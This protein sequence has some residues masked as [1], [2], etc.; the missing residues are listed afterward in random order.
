MP[1]GPTRQQSH[2][3]D[4]VQDFAVGLEFSQ[5]NIAIL[6]QNTVPHGIDNGL[7]LFVDFFEQEVFITFFLGSNRVPRDLARYVLYRLA[8]KVAEAHALASDFGHFSIVKEDH[9]TRVVEECGNIGSDEVFIL[10]ETNNDRRGAFCSQNGIG[11]TLRQRNNGKRA[12]QSL[13]CCASGFSKRKSILNILVNQ[14][15]N[16]L[17][18]SF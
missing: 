17:S 15:R 6:D 18:I 2:P 5:G 3:F 14:M 10:S 13:E 4:C 12:C 7:R 1:R 16:N 8:V 11:L 9:L